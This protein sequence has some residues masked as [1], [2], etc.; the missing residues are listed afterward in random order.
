MFLSRAIFA[1]FDRDA[2]RIRRINRLRA[3][4]ARLTDA[5]LR[6]ASEQAEDT[7]PFFAAAASAAA[8]VLGQT[9]YDV[10]L[11]GALALARGSIAEMQTGE[12]KTLAAVPAIAWLARGGRGVHVMT[13]ND[14]LAR[15]D[16]QWMGGVY[17]MLGF[18]VGY[19]QQGMSASERRAAYA[20]D[21]LYATANE[22]GFDYLRDGMATSVEEQVQREFAA[23]VIDEA[24]S[25]LIDEARVPLVIAGGSAEGGG[26]ALAAD[27]AVRGLRAGEHY[28]LDVGAHNVSLT[29]EGIGVVERAL[30]CGNLFDDANLRIHTAVQDAL[31]AHALVKRDVEYLVRDSAIEMVDE[32]NGRVAQDRRWPAGLQTAIEAKEGVASKA[33][34]MIL[35]QITLQRLATM[36]PHLCGMTGTASTQSFELL[37]VYGLRVEK[38]PTESSAGK[39]G[40][41][42]RGVSQQGGKGSGGGGGGAAGA[43]DGAAGAGG[44][45]ERGGIGAAERDADGRAA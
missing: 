29:D 37:K 22:I 7:L 30:G 21:V 28:R 8:R 23:A 34:G 20:C 6:S 12:G 2:K 17:R 35:G 44:D 41:R 43:C 40:L 31:D 3:G 19:L 27:G 32:F 10:Q 39:G 42:G 11:R 24:D 5:E 26:L 45:G 9:M 18:R 25:I 1:P 33:Q 16:A 15:R 36:Y 4:F 14:Y 13:A 38:I